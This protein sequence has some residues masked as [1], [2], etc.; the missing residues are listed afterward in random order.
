MIH[1]LS[2][3]CIFRDEFRY[4]REW[5]EFHRLVG[6]EHFY[7]VCNDDRVEPARE[8]LADYIQAGLIDLYHLPK[9]DANSQQIQAYR[10]VISEARSKWVAIIDMDEFLFSPIC[11]DVREVL[12]DYERYGAVCINWACFGSGGHLYP[13]SLQTQELVRRAHDTDLVNCYVKSVIDPSRTVAP[14]NAHTF[15]H[16]PSY[17]AVDEFDQPIVPG[18][19]TNPH[20]QFFGR[21]LRINHYRVRSYLD[22]LHKLKRWSG[23]HIQLRGAEDS[24]KYWASEDRNEC[25]D[26]TLLRFGDR[27]REALR[28]AGPT[29]RLRP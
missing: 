15:R 9:N 7:M 29:P 11:D 3:G 27:L 4:M 6:V 1:Y 14:L 21:R 18:R 2:A 23:E 25:L 19:C 28:R 12:S 22:F 26:T 10:M 5:V 20:P 17:P 16:D 8:F 13:V 24:Q